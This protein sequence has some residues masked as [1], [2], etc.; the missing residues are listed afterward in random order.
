MARP[1]EATPK[2]GR[3]ATKAFLAKVEADLKV[4]AYP[5]PTPKLEEARRFVLNH[6]VLGPKKG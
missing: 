3:K 6:A 5:R 2:L 4:P 1:I